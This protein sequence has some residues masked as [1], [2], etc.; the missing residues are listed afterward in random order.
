MIPSE[1]LRY[2]LSVIPG[3]AKDQCGAISFYVRQGRSLRVDPSTAR[4]KNAAPVR[5]T[6]WERLI[7]RCSTIFTVMGYRA[8]RSRAGRQSE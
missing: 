2:Y 6:N 8:E 3:E 4:Q 1:L 5:M 7:N